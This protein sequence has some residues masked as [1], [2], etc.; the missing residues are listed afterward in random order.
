MSRISIIALAFLVV[1]L[2]LA[3]SSLFTVTQTEQALLV[4]FGQIVRPIEDPGLH[5]K[6]PLIQNVI[7]FDKRRL[8]LGDGEQ[9]A[10]GK[11]Q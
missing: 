9:A 6:L 8:C 1:L 4:Q 10:A 11:T 5:A 2:G 7:T 3:S